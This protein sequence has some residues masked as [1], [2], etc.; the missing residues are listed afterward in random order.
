MPYVIAE[1]CIGVKDGRCADVCPTDA[2]HTT[3]DADQFYVDPDRCIDCRACELICP[4]D[5]I[6]TADYELPPKWAQ[7]AAIN[8]DFFKK[9]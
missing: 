7:Y 9:K 3:E 4:V 5:A 6:F 1:P 2:I 8:A